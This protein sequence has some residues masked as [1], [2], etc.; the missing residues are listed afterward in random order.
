[1]TE[2]TEDPIPR[3]PTAIWRD[4]RK[5]LKKMNSKEGFKH[6]KNAE[7]CAFDIQRLQHEFK[8]SKAFHI[9]LAPEPGSLIL[10]DLLF[11]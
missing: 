1:M 2:Q 11:T 6:S 8:M 4:L 3:L 7:E 10:T 9:G 5:K